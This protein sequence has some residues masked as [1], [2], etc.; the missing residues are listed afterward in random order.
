[1]LQGKMA[2]RISDYVYN[3]WDLLVSKTVTAQIC[4]DLWRSHWTLQR[5][6]FNL[7]E[8]VAWKPCC[9]EPIFI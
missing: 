9:R 1:M 8:A 5:I 3:V 2:F 6:S 4:S 7:L